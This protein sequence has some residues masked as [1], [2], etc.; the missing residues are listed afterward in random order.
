M[1][2]S[3]EIRIRRQRVFKYQLAYIEVFFKELCFFCLFQNYAENTMNELLGLFGYEDKV[4]SADTENLNLDN[5]A[6][7]KENGCDVTSEDSPGEKGG[8]SGRKPI[9]RL[10]SRT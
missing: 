8:K 9:I 3:E 4:N 1:L 10:S 2:C 6:D 7:S 5:Y